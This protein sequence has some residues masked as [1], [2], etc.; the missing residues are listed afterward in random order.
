MISRACVA[1]TNTYLISG[2]STNSILLWKTVEVSQSGSLLN[3]FKSLRCFNKHIFNI[4][5]QYQVYSTMEVSQSG[6]LLN[7]FKSLR[8]FNKH[9]FNIRKQYQVYS[10]ME[11][12]G[13]LSIWTSSSLH[14]TRQDTVPSI[15]QNMCGPPSV[16]N[17]QE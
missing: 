12:C 7:D 14:P 3:D 13:S 17:W 1:S 15:R 5:K 16:E 4:R 10:T 2:S 6:S 9:I 11:D 8:C